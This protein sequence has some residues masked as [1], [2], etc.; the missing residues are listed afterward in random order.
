MNKQYASF[1]W[2]PVASRLGF[3]DQIQAGETKWFF[4]V[5]NQEQNSVGT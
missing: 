3:G 5:R 1:C 2:S 4:S